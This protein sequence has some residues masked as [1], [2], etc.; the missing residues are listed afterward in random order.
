[1]GGQK[2]EGKGRKKRDGKAGQR[3]GRAPETAYSR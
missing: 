2:W 1:M 3:R